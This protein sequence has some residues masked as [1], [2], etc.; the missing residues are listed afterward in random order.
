VRQRREE[1]GERKRRN[2][3]SVNNEG[4]EGNTLH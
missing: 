1:E 3:D 4:V 2:V